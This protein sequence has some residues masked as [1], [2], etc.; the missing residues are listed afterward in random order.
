MSEVMRDI[1]PLERHK[2]LHKRL[3]EL[4]ERARSI[5]RRINDT[6]DQLLGPLEKPEK[7]AFPPPDV[8][9]VVVAPGLLQEIEM[10]SIDVEKELTFLQV[11][12]ERLVGDL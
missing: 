2:R 1:E 3:I 6:S 10:A 5:S 8:P 7:Q 11:S 4:S 9:K 12:L